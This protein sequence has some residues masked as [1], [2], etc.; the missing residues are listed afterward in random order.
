MSE[1]A[2][3]VRTATK[4]QNEN[5]NLVDIKLRITDGKVLALFRALEKIGKDSVVGHDLL[6][7]LDK[8]YDKAGLQ[9]H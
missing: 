6:V 9:C 5:G 8:A 1:S 7:M 3:M 4:N 2:V